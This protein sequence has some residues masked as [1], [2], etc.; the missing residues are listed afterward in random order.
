MQQRHTLIL[1]ML[2]QLLAA[3][4]LVQPAQA[5][6]T[7]A[8]AGSVFVDGNGNDLAEPQEARVPGAL[9]HLRSQ[10]DPALVFS[11][12]ADA[13]GYFVLR[14]LPY[15]VYDVWASAGD[16]TGQ[17]LLVVEIAEVNAQVLLDVPVSAAVAGVSL[18]RER[19]IFLPLVTVN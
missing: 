15:G 18:G 6:D 4:L 1:L 11:A 16:Q 7:G 19:A 5:A 13:N 9:V 8:L 3:L 17:R 10:A 14:D 12:A 2:V